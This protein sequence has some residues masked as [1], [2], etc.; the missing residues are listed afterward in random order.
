MRAD[1][2]ND[3]T[4]ALE[5]AMDRLQAIAPNVTPQWLVIE[6]EP[7]Q[8]LRKVIEDDEDIAVLVLA[9]G[10]SKNGPGPLV[11]LLAGQASA[12]YPIPITLVP[13]NLSDKE[14]EALA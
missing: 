11:S 10:T 5:K 14:I 8:V 1:A 13:G 9:A 12:T 7:A 4:Q 2:Q 6:G 3:A